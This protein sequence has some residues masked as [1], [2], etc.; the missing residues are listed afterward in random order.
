MSQENWNRWGADDER[1]A[2][3]HIDAG[4]VKRAAPLVTEGRVISLAQPL[5]A[6]IPFPPHRL[7]GTISFDTEPGIELAAAP[8]LA[9][10]E[11][12]VAGAGSPISPM[13]MLQSTVSMIFPI[14]W[15]DSIS[16]CASATRS[17]PNV[18]CTTGA[19]RP[20]SNT[21][22]IFSRNSAAI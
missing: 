17:S 3:N 5:S 4:A 20:A 2:L 7:A 1:G 9:E 22:Q 10:R 6:R 15:L 8:W 16:R 14:C 18:A 19:Q 11:V 13:A 12:T 21:G